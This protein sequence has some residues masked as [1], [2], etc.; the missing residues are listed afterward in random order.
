MRGQKEDEGVV[1][2]CLREMFSSLG[3][4]GGCSCRF[5]ISYFEVYNETI[6][7]LLS[8]SNCSL[9]I[10][11]SKIN[12][13]Y[14][15][16]LSEFDVKSAKEAIKYFDQGE[17]QRSYGA[18]EIND[19]SSRSHVI[20]RV[21]IE[22]R[23][24]YQLNKTYTSYLTLVDL[25]GSEAITKSK[26]KGLTQRE[27]SSI[28]KSLLSLSNII[29][30]LNK[31]GGKKFI[32]FRESKLT[33]L[34]QPILSG[35]SKTIVIC[36]V[37]PNADHLQESINTLRFGITAGGIKTTVAPK[38]IESTSLSKEKQQEIEVLCKRNEELEID[39]V[40]LRNKISLLEIS[41]D[42]ERSKISA[43]QSNI[44]LFKKFEEQSRRET[45]NLIAD[46]EELIKLLDNYEAKTLMRIRDA[47]REYSIKELK[48]YSQSFRYMTQQFQ[49]IK[50][51]RDEDLLKRMVMS[52]EKN[53]KGL[54]NTFARE[55]LFKSGKKT[56]GKKK[57]KLKSKSCPRSSVKRPKTEIE[58][59][60][61][62]EEE[63]SKENEIT[64]LKDTIRNL[65]ADNRN[66]RCEIND[67]LT[68]PICSRSAKRSKKIQGTP[69]G[70]KSKIRCGTI[71][72]SEDC[73]DISNRNSEGSGE[74]QQS[75]MPQSKIRD[76][77]TPSKSQLKRKI[78]R[79]ELELKR[80][81]EREQGLEK[82]L[83]IKNQIN[84][85]MLEE[86]CV[87]KPREPKTPFSI[88]KELAFLDDVPNQMA[89][90]FKTKDLMD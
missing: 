77:M 60:Q 27:G 7:D 32:G 33:R 83:K 6:S 66:L 34:F 28:N 61:V 43:L 85:K 76:L 62:K 63:I 54:V 68:N 5:K 40:S 11:E 2:H 84:N 72:H 29:M 53:V 45:Q 4:T 75:R 59:L 20:L 48:H 56:K 81:R 58:M 80:A 19:K 17:R 86:I 46:K 24:K 69:F 14:I 39:N 90:M 87:N 57:N 23:F 38:E 47:V 50:S 12:G 73:N 16:N 71:L 79:N 26:A 3:A 8:R 25:A 49:I 1:L 70:S 44:Q 22:T 65:K 51:E 78:H 31:G 89:A 42:T 36:T 21:R 88:G 74:D 13:I 18:T 82:Q 15:E 55:T 30:K 37:N 10:R 9:E 64:K 35:N 67:L 41:L 52:D